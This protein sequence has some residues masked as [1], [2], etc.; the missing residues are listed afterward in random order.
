MVKEVTGEVHNQGFGYSYDILLKDGVIVNLEG[1]FPKKILNEI[2]KTKYRT[3]CETIVAVIDLDGVWQVFDASK[4][5]LVFTDNAE[6]LALEDIEVPA[7]KV[8]KRRYYYKG[9]DL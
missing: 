4:K 8:E 1:R 2:E 6:L 5:K 3:N 7:V 9:L